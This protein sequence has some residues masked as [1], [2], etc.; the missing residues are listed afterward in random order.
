VKRL[1]L[2]LFVFGSLLLPVSAQALSLKVPAGFRIKPFAEG[3]DHPR[4]MAVSPKGELFVTEIEKG[5][6]VVLTDKNQDGIAEAK[7]IFAQGLNRPHGIAFYKDWLYVG[8]T[9]RVVRYAYRPGQRPSQGIGGK[10]QVIVDGLPPG[11]QHSTR[12]LAFGPDNKLYVSVGSSCNSCKEESPERA[13]ILQYN[14]DGSGKKIYARGLRNAVG[15]IF[16]GKGRLWATSNG[17]DQLGDNIP[18]DELHQVTEGMQ[19]GW[20]FCHAGKYPDPDR[21]LAR[22]GSCSEVNKPA[23]NFQAHSAPLG[24]AAY[25]G[26]QFPKDYQGDLIIAFH[27]SWN[28]SIP[29]G[30]KL[31][32]AH[33]EG[34]R[35]TKV[36]DFI[37][38]WL[39]SGQIISG[40]PVDVVNSPDGGLWVS[41]DE[42]G[43]IY[44]ISYSKI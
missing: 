41:D 38:G 36:T 24:L 15:L 33:M 34:D 37:T 8:E 27:G 42:E 3:L 30:Y 20:P 9:G 29:T 17:R 43:K 6:V 16:D 5:Q 40:R 22:L 10:P 23:W 32:R 2:G 18:P 13:T 28:R 7:T 44:K 19:G 25:Q 31:V 4:F 14:P 21:S 12:T 39:D 35:V 26:K 11:G 1:I